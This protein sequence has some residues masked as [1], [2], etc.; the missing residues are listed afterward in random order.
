MLARYRENFDSLTM[1][2]AAHVAAAIQSAYP[3]VPVGDGAPRPLFE[4]C[5][6]AG[7]GQADVVMSMA[8]DATALGVVCLEKIVGRPIVRPSE[9]PAAQRTPRTPR[10]RGPAVRR[11]DPRV[12]LSVAPNPKKPGSKSWPRY[13]LYRVGMTVSEFVE[14]GGS[15][16]DVAWDT[17]RGFIK[18]GEVG[19]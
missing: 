11:T 17:E 15:M 4:I 16:A 2:E 14:A 6:E 5:D 12:I 18:L 19:E 7:L 9:R 13:E 8:R 10:V 1:E 3:D